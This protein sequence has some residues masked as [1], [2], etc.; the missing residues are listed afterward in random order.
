MDTKINEQNILKTQ[1]KLIYDW[2]LCLYMILKFLIFKVP[3]N[4]VPPFPSKFM[5]DFNLSKSFAFF[6]SLV[7]SLL[8]ELKPTI[9][10]F[11]M[12]FSLRNIYP[13]S[14]LQF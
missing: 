6:F 8:L 12:S 11:R 14:D 5:Y 1:S 2:R 7:S 13:S 10:P 9:S 4:L 3:L